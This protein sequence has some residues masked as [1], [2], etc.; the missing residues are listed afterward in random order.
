MKRTVFLFFLLGVWMFLVGARAGYAVSDSIILLTIDGPITSATQTYLS[1]G[2]E[3]AERRGAE[4]VILQL[5]TPGGSI[6]SLQEMI[7]SIRNSRVPVVVYVAPRGAWAASAGALLTLAGHAS[8]MAPETA[9]G[10]ASPVGGEGEDLG[11]TMSAKVRNQMK[12]MISPL[13]AHRPQPAQEMAMKMIDEAEAVSSDEA[14][15]M[16]LIDFIAEDVPTLLQQL[17]GFVVQMP[18]GPRAL[19]TQGLP[20]EQIN[21]SLIEQILQI[22]VNPNVVLILLGLGVQAILIEL[23]SPGGWV[24]GFLGVVCL[25]LAAY[26]LGF[27]SV[28]WFGLIF[29]GIAFVLFILDIKA[30]ASGGLTAAGI[31]SFIVGALVLFNSPGTP[32]FQRVSIPLVVFWRWRSERPLP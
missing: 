1:R 3:L 20:V 27:L 18:T 2:L 29:L 22:L 14:L 9:I 25:A 17:D 6:S 23:S 15:K 7:S 8:A 5:D 21:F 26:G 4:V 13:V 19:K 24:A 31:G 16:G 12:A 10:A 32:E 30:G 11:E 28:N